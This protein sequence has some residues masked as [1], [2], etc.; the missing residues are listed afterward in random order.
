ML[1]FLGD[2]EYIILK[3]LFLHLA[4]FTKVKTLNYLNRKRKFT[5][6]THPHMLVKWGN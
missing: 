3:T 5:V 1:I 2:G 6:F 4:F